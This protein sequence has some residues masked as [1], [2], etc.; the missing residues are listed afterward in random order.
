MKLAYWTK[1]KGIGGK[2]K[3]PEDFVVRE[4]I[5]K[6][7]LRKYSVNGSIG[8]PKKYNLL[9][10]RKRNITTRAAI[11]ELA[12]KLNIPEKAF[13]YA[14][15]KDKFS[16]SFQYITVKSE[17]EIEKIDLGNVTIIETRK[18]DKFLSKGNLT[19][20]EFEIILHGCKGG[21]RKIIT[22][23]E[24]HGMPNFFGPQRFGKYQDNHIIGKL[25]LKRRFDEALRIIN[26]HDRKHRKISDIPKDVL[27]FY[28]HAYQSW[29]FNAALSEYIRKEKKSY[30]KEVR[31][32]GY[33]TN[34]K[35]NK[36]EA[37]MKKL[38]AKDGI[39]P[40][41]FMISELRMSVGGARRMA[42]IKVKIK[43]KHQKNKLNLYFT[44]PKG[45]YATTVMREITKINGF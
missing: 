30:F 18:T 4:I 16:I 32:P 8:R 3:D 17:K 2:I 29:L 9:L 12:R 34:L 1:S 28:I 11:K 43:Y 13:G 44:L 20:N 27:K 31:I 35:N 38:L 5:S 45:S 23:I 14:G 36:I 26:S 10:I 40:I 15:L 41:D 25:L 7:F 19:G 37:I 39:N 33:R 42:F 21:A 6:K 22:E 24:K